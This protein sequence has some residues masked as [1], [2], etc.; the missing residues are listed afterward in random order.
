MV[1]NLP[2]EDFLFKQTDVRETPAATATA[3]AVGLTDPTYVTLSVN[4]DLNNERVLTA[5]EGMNLTD[6]GAGTT[7]TVSGEDATD[8]NKGIG[9]F[10][11]VD[12]TVASGAVSL[13]DSVCKT[14]DGDTGTATAVTHNFD[15]LGGTAIT[16]AG[17]GN[18]ITITNSGVTSAVAGGGIDVSGATG[19]VT[20]SGEDA[21]TTN[22]GVASFNTNH[23]TVAS[24]AVSLKTLT[25][26]WSCSGSNFVP[27]Y[28]AQVDNDFQYDENQVICGSTTATNVYAP[29]FLPH[30]ATITSIIVTGSDA[31]N[32]WNFYRDNTIKAT[33]A[34]NT[35]DTSI[36][37]PIVNNQSYTY[38]V[39]AALGTD[40]SIS[41]CKI[42][43]TMVN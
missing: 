41:S 26:Y 23:F 21:T 30:G 2:G 33:A 39:R 17:S 37:D 5:G 24:G 27:E 42:T 14:I 40:D 10:V 32:T 29:V 15:I 31:G 34:V 6:G 4:A 8:A 28:W 7:I 22:K 18:D 35:A 1:L 16:T 3:T 43:Y 9:S 19:A 11:L 20:I 36:T 25:R 13:K 38:T 12:F